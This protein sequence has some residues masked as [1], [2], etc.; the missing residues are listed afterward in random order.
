MRVNHFDEVCI[1]AFRT[2]VDV[3]ERS[4]K[5]Y[6]SG[7]GRL[8][9]ARLVGDAAQLTTVLEAVLA[10]QHVVFDVDGGSGAASPLE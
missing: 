6:P 10:A 4:V 3:C 9:V 5:Q 2:S 1:V 8:V 7:E